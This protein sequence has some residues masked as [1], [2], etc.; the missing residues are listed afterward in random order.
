[1][2]IQVILPSF[3][4]QNKNHNAKKLT[5]KRLVIKKIYSSPTGFL[6]G[7]FMCANT[8]PQTVENIKH[9]SRYLRCRWCRTVAEVEIQS[10]KRWRACLQSE[11]RPSDASLPPS[12]FKFFQEVLQASGLSSSLPVTFLGHQK[13]K[14]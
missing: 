12:S 10:M 5:R 3:E 9:I 6:Y 2:N 7:L 4:K 14:P 8:T 11:I 13:N 1:M